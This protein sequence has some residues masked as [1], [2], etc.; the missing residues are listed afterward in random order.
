V[1]PLLEVM[2]TVLVSAVAVFS[3]GHVLLHKRDPRSALGWVSVS[4]ALPVIGPLFYWLL[5]VNRIRTR[6]RDWQTQ[7][8]ESQGVRSGF[9]SWSSRQQESDPFCHEDYASLLSLAD[10]VTRRPLLAGN[11]VTVLHN[12]EGAYPAMLEAMAD[13]RESIYLSTY[14]FD[15]DTSGRV[16]ATALIEAAGRGLDVRVLVDGFGERYSFPLARHLFR[17]TPVHF[18]RFLPPALSD[19]GLHFNLRNHR[20][21]LIIDRKRGFTGGM[22]IGDRHLA[23]LP[24]KRQAVDMHFSVEGPV[25]GQMLEAFMEDWHFVTGDEFPTIGYLPPLP[26]GEAFCRGIS[27]GP[28]EDF[29]KLRWIYLGAINCARKCI[30]LM[31]PY[32]I[33]DSTLMAALYAA[34]LRGVE[35]NLVLPEKSNLPYVDWAS[36]AYFSE[37][38]EYGVRLFLQPPP[39]AHG[40]LAL[41]DDQYSLI[42]SANLDS[43]SLRLNFEFN[44]EIYD[45]RLTGELAAHFDEVCGR[46][47]T[48]TAEE[49]E[50]QALPV[51]LRN[52]LTKLFSPYL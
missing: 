11:R 4:F 39:F 3:A 26:G 17:H 23:G 28:N 1:L 36:R 15:A 46:S 42:G 30:R 45:Q 29:E 25:V 6:A 48:V 5:G 52:G 21:L 44:L 19:K 8:R 7:L 16:I 47:K 31:T 34:V 24:G 41:I 38:L 20:K 43:R 35:V 2:L 50:K 33:P 9:C 10:R 27:A 37:L 22:N 49:I 51:R 40:K 18:A 14:I 32:F 12:G 13:A